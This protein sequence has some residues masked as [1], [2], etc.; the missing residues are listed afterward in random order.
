MLIRKYSAFTRLSLVKQN[1]TRAKRFRSLMNFAANN[2][3]YYRGVFKSIDP[4]TTVLQDLPILT[5]QAMMANFDRFHTDSNITSRDASAW[6]SDMRNYGSLFQ[7]KYIVYHTS[8]SQG[9]AAIIIQDHKTFLHLFAMQAARGHAMPKTWRTLF[10]KI[11]RR[12]SRWSVLLFK[13]A[14]IPSCIT[15]KHMPPMLRRLVDYQELHF[16]DSLPEIIHQLENFQPDYITGYPH[17]LEKIAHAVE[18]TGSSL[19][20]SEYLQLLITISEPLDTATQHYLKSVYGVPVANHYGM[21]ECPELTLGCPL[22]NGSH[23]NT[24][25]AI[26]ENVD[27]NY[28]AVPDGSPGTKVLVTNLMNFVQPFIRYEVDDVVTISRQPCACGNPF[29]LITRVE[30]RANDLFYIQTKNGDIQQVSYYLFTDS[31]LH[32]LEIAEY[33]VRQTEMNHFNILLQPT[34]GAVL[35]TLGLISSIHNKF[36]KEGIHADLHISIEIVQHIHRNNQ[37]GKFR[38]FINSSVKPVPQTTNLVLSSVRSA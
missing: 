7:D 12:R 14:F 24:D 36:I 27:D 34:P 1:E 22:G 23:I 31:F 6:M 28:E 33:Q 25:M 17:V 38:R 13:D 26:L 21:G 29:P 30:G 3:P 20:K 5:K 19:T 11:Y 16:T 32:C 37:S 2:S 18:S 8:G 4:G 10:A 9:Q 15:F 35:D